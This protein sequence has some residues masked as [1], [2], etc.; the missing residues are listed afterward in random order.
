MADVVSAIQK[1]C[2]EPIC[3]IPACTEISLLL[4]FAPIEKID[5]MDALIHHTIDCYLNKVS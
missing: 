4:K 2:R 1:R 3:F 5:T